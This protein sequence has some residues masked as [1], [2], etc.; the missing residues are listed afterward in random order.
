MPSQLYR[1]YKNKP[2]K[3][4]GTVLHSETLEELVLYQT[5]YENPSGKIWVRPKQMFFENVQ[6]NGQEKPRFENLS[7]QIFET[8]RIGTSE[9]ET[10]APLIR[11]IFGEWDPNWFHSTLKNHTQFYLC[12]ASIENKFVGFKIGYE[13]DT[14]DFYSWLGGVLP[15]FRGVGLAQELMRIQHQWCESKGYKKIST[16]TQ[17]RFKSMLLLNLKSGFQIIGTHRSEDGD[18]LKI[19][20]EKQLQT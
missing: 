8:T 14:W 19:I 11:E 6:V 15:E 12:L 3:F 20:L 10:L 4:L 7:F 17:N 2:Y 9:I 5:R 13:K 18:G 1:H 16:K